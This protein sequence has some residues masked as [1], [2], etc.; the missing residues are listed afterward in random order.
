[1]SDLALGRI[2]NLIKGEDDLSKLG[3]LREQF[4]KEKQALDR[5]VLL[6][7]E[8]QIDSIMTN[9]KN[10]NVAVTKLNSIK[11]NIGKVNSIYEELVDKMKDYDTI[12]KMSGVNQFLSQVSDLYVDILRF[13]E[14]LD[15]LNQI[16][17]KEYLII[18]EDIKYTLPN[19]LLI[20]YSVTQARNFLDYLVL[21]LGLSDDFK[22]IVQRIIQPMKTTV[23]AFD[24]L[25]GEVIVS[26]TEAARDGNMELVYKLIKIIHYEQNADLQCQLMNGLGLNLFLDVKLI[27][28]RKFRGQPRGYVKFFYDKL[29]DGLNETF[30]ACVEH[31]GENKMGV[32]DSLQWLEDELIYVH[33][34]LNP[35]FPETWGLSEFIQNVYYNNLHKFTISVVNLDPP[36][37]DLMRILA[38]DTHYNKFIG[39]LQA[40]PSK[41]EKRP[42]SLVK[43]EQRSIIGDD[44]KTSILEDYLKLIVTKMQEWNTNLM[45]RETEVFT[46]RE[47]PP[48]KYLYQQTYDDEDANDQL[49]QVEIENEV[50]V[51]PDFK[52]PLTMLKEQADVAADLGYSKVL[53]GVLENW[54]RGYI[55]RILNYQKLIDDDYDR[56]MLVFNNERYLER[57]STARKFFGGGSKR[58][59]VDVENMLPEELDKISPKGLVEYLAALGNTYEINTDRLQDRFLD[60]YKDKVHSAY[61]GRIEQAFEDILVPTT[62]L[63][64]RIISILV[65]IIINDIT[66]GLSRLFTKQWY[67]NDG[68]QAG[69]EDPLATQIVDTIALYLYDL[70]LYCTYEFYSIT[71][72][73]LLSRFIPLYIRAGL[74]NI[75][76]G[77][78]KKIDPNNVKKFRLFPEAIGRDV[79]IFY[80][81]LVSLFTRRDSHILVELLRAIE[82]LGEIGTCPNPLEFIPAMWENEILAHFY[83][84]SVEYVRGI[85]MCRKDMDKSQVNTLVTKLEDIQRDY[86]LKVEPPEFT[87]GTLTEF[88]I[89]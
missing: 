29:E 15:E 68:H 2:A 42:K 57:E 10:L 64:G 46:K 48:D 23:I 27:D 26:L 86:H 78:G 5:Q 72:L 50:Y 60:S 73:V 82:Y 45:N 37:E 81:G 16:I 30:N 52:T 31:F 39:S 87:L 61:H 71:T 21:D 36:A 1:M 58:Q 70:R 59:Q 49:I 43:K 17:E 41:G 53:V 62:D 14:Y 84:C 18:S 28:Y 47:E 25:L 9:L 12:K 20:H 40:P 33:Q 22:L 8:S 13:R 56:Y 76:H 24:K 89:S 54:S 4:I 32:F 38:Y 3:V 35:L 66:P 65:D 19:L 7:T 75:L 44:L 79:T 67:E 34:E 6:A 77:D 85:C 63:N 83:L 51:L 55:E 11:G 69:G 74:E 80:E 88:S